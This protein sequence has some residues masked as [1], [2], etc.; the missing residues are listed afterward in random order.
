MKAQRGSLS[1]LQFASNP[2]M[3]TRKWMISLEN[4]PLRIP[5]EGDDIQPAMAV[6]EGRSEPGNVKSESHQLVSHV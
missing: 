1:E 5:G 2:I 3:T 4:L 6:I